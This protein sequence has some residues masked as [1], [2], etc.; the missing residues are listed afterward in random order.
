MASIAIQQNIANKRE[1]TIRACSI[2][3]LTNGKN[4]GLSTT[5]LGYLKIT[6]IAFIV[7][8]KINQLLARKT[9]IIDRI[10]INRK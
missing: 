8:L 4:G 9:E 6:M 5:S 10:K 2:S 3:N 1:I 7:F